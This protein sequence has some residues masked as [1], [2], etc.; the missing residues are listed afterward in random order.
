MKYIYASLVIIP[1]LLSALSIE[2]AVRQTI[3]TN[4]QV[5][6]KKEGLKV[7]SK[8][9]TSVESGY[10]PSVDLRYAAGPETTR[11]I[12]NQRNSVS[13]NRQEASITLTQNLFSGFD[14]RASVNQQQA[15]IE[16]SSSGVSDKSNSM[17]LE[18][19]TA[20]V[21]VLRTK[22]L[23]DIA[24]DN[25]NVHKKYLDQIKEKVDAG[26]GTA[27]DY[28]QTLSRYENAQSTLFL[29][30][31]N[32][33]NSISSFNRILPL[34]AKAED[35]VKPTIG[36]LPS[37]DLDEL[38]AI[39]IQNNPF[40]KSSQA[41]V[42]YARATK[43]KSKATNY[44]TADIIA[45][46]YWNKNLNGITDSV[47]YPGDVVSDNKEDGHNVLLVVNY[48]IF[49]GM[50]DQSN[51]EANEYK[52]LQ[53]NSLLEDAKRFVEANTKIAL[54]TFKSTQEQLVH[55]NKNIEASSQTVAAYQEEHDLGRR[56]IID[57]LNIELEYN[58]AKNRKVTAL[59]DHALAY[60]QILTH[61][62]KILEAMNA[63]S[64]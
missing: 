45:S 41:E 8:L 37:E 62:G 23:F 29:T 57:L 12:G 15:R 10:L 11:T 53:Q 3:E 20:Y 43:E 27:S 56:S 19:I 32:Y 46:A 39:A 64:K 6:A 60:Y 51:Q 44:P 58:G 13:A 31:Q 9:L 52:V 7:E 55:I 22:E 35:L 40:I 34:D 4:P 48:N 61:T 16:S 49:N 30:E 24:N 5:Q 18:S 2:E 63:D 38:L 54:Q 59:Y 21:E 47:E 1:S 25:V 36:E 50:A 28:K 42:S 26:V 33:K 14:T 17:A